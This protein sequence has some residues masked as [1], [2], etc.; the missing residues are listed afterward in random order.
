MVTGKVPIDRVIG[1]AE[2]GF[3]CL[4]E[5]ELV[6]LNGTDDIFWTSG[7]AQ[8]GSLPAALS[9]WVYKITEAI[10]ASKGGI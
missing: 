7:H 9:D 8:K 4:R 2:S 6:V 10:K 3:G 5:S 1:G